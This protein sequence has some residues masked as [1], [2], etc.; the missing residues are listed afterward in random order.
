MFLVGKHIPQFILDLPNEALDSPMGPMLRQMMQ[1]VQDAIRDRSIGHQVDPSAVNSQRRGGASSSSTQPRLTRRL[2]E[3]TKHL[4]TTAVV[5]DRSNRAVVVRKLREYA[6]DASGKQNVN[7]LVN[8][9]MSL[10][11]NHA[12][13]ALDLLRLAVAEDENNCEIVARTMPKLIA[14]FGPDAENSCRPSFMMLLRCA[15]NCFYTERGAGPL[16]KDPEIAYSLLATT[17]AGLNYDHAGVKKTA[18]MLALNL[19]GAQYRFPS[20][21]PKLSDDNTIWVVSTLSEKL[22]KD[23]S[24]M[25]SEE[26]FHVISALGVLTGDNPEAFQLTQAM[27]VSL[28]RYADPMYGDDPRYDDVTRR[29]AERT[30]KMLQDGLSED[31]NEQLD[32]QA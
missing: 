6:P 11:E 24:L 32:A 18:A 28:E 8:L 20:A 13:P 30:Q 7:E 4:W 23:A 19:A 2:G 1:S 12:F 25:P 21:V 31:R 27:E 29:V 17:I 26:A 10:P 5:L 22:V 9:C 16:L 3:K 14:R 15:V